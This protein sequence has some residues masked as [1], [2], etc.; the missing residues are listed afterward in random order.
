MFHS[1]GR[2]TL[3][4]RRSPAAG[5]P[6]G[7]RASSVRLEPD[8]HRTLHGVGIAPRVRRDLAMAPRTLDPDIDKRDRAPNQ[9]EMREAQLLVGRA[10]PIGADGLDQRGD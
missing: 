9:V 3:A 8:L 1:T 5:G 4:P 7:Q 2:W 10:Q 6:L